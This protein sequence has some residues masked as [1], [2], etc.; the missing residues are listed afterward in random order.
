MRHCKTGIP[1]RWLAATEGSLLPH[2]HF[3][4]SLKKNEPCTQFRVGIIF[5]K[6]KIVWN[7]VLLTSLV[8]D[9]DKF[10]TKLDRTEH[11]IIYIICFCHINPSYS[12]ITI[13]YTPKQKTNPIQILNKKQSFDFTTLFIWFHRSRT[14]S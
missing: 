5:L 11:M 12:I 8:H 2:Y 1:Q 7:F 13:H 10:F 3:G 9:P 6:K 4:T 14:W